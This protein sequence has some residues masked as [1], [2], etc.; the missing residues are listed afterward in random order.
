M[1][2]K[3]LHIFK[4]VVT[5]TCLTLFFPFCKCW[6]ENVGL[7]SQEEDDTE[8]IQVFF[9]RMLTDL[10]LSLPPCLSTLELS[11]ESKFGPSVFLYLYIVF[12]WKS[13]SLI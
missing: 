1:H 3:S 12:G 10:C 11:V 8:Y 5:L 6:I 2:N 9:V 4:D 7:E 13:A